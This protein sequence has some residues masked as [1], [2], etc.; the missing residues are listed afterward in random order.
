MAHNIR[1]LIVENILQIVLVNRTIYFPL[2]LQFGRGN[3]FLQRI[4]VSKRS[5]T[6]HNTLKINTIVKDY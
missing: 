3:I 2:G 1:C 5:Q 6:E 4:Q